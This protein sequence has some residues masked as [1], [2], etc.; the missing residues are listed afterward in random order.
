MLSLPIERLSPMR[1]D[2][3]RDFGAIEIIFLLTYLLN[4]FAWCIAAPVMISHHQEVHITIAGV[5][6]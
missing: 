3:P 2:S 6:E 1:P 5:V 4:A